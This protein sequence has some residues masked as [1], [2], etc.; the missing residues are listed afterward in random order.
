MYI[1]VKRARQHR[2]MFAAQHLY[3]I[4]DVLS[5]FT[6]FLKKKNADIS[7]LLYKVCINVVQQ[8]LLRQYIWH[9]INKVK[10]SALHCFGGGR[11][12][13]LPPPCFLG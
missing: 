8:I 3:N 2:V 6:F 12:P 5:I 10:W 1:S 13:R 4:T 9:H 11:L 7:I